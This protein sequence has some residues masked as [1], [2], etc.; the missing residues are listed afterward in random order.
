MS[1]YGHSARVRKPPFGKTML[2]Q[3]FA[4]QLG[5][6]MLAVS[7]FAWNCGRPLDVNY[8]W[9]A[10]SRSGARTLYHDMQLEDPFCTVFS[11]PCGPWGRWS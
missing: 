4:G 5:L 6:T 11:A 8:G 2:K 3:L 9:D 7:A 1:S 10:G